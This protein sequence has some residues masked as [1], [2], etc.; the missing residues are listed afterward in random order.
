MR[1]EPLPELWR[2]FLLDL[3]KQLARPTELHCFGGFVVAQCY[4]LTRPT[5]DIDILDSKGT[6][7]ITIAKLAGGTS[8]PRHVHQ[9]CHGRRLMWR[10]GWDS[11]PRAGYPTR[12][13]RGAPVTTTS[14][15][16]RSRADRLRTDP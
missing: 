4:G 1:S 16:L 6:D 12:R 5:V 15:P 11:N 13:F 8:P 7:L 10:R 3:D 14:V 2:S 9:R